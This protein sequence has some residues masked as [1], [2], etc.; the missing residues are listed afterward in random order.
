MSPTGPG[1]PGP[2]PARPA[3]PAQRVVPWLVP[4]L[5]GGILAATVLVV[6]LAIYVR[7]GSDDPPLAVV[8]RYLAAYPDRDCETLMDVVTREWWTSEGRLTSDEALRRCRSTEG[9]IELDSAFAAVGVLTQ[10]SDRA[11]VG[12]EVTH[13]DGQVVTDEVYLRR[14]GGTWRVDPLG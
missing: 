8:E 1:G 5:V 4:W 3:P 7:T 9:Q 12:I 2:R 6:G 11:V 13:G 10:R 14:Q